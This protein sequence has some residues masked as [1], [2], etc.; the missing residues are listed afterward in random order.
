MLRSMLAIYCL[1]FGGCGTFSDALC[2]PVTNDAYYRG[3]RLDVRQP[4]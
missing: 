4:A 3:V 2:G 1:S